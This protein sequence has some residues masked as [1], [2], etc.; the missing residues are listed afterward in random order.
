ME[1]DQEG[2]LPGFPSVPVTAY[3][4]EPATAGDE[5]QFYKSQEGKD[6]SYLFEPDFHSWIPD[7]V[8]TTG[9][10]ASVLGNTFLN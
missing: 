9:E 1:A 10:E 2:H 7:T 4:K 8:P 3:S 5:L 6:K